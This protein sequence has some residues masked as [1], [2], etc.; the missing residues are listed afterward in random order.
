M[1]KILL[2]TACVLCIAKMAWTEEMCID[3]VGGGTYSTLQGALYIAASNGE[4]DTIKVVQGT[5]TRASGNFNYY[6]TEGK[7]I[8][9]RGGYTAGCAAGVED[10]SLTILDASGESDTDRVLSILNYGSGNIEID[11]FT[12]RNGI[13]SA[14]IGGPGGGIYA[15]CYPSTGPAGDITIQNNII[16]NNSCAETYGGGGVAATSYANSS[17]SSGN[18][19]FSNN[20]VTGNT[21]DR[22]GGGIAIGSSSDSGI[23]GSVTVSNNFIDGNMTIN[24]NG[25]GGGIYAAS[26]SN[27]GT[28]GS[29]LLTGNTITGNISGGHGG[30]AATSIST[31]AGGS[32][33]LITL[34]DNIIIG[35]SSTYFNGHGG[36]VYI[37]TQTFGTGKAGSAVLTNNII[38]GN[39]SNGNTAFGGGL[40]ADSYTLTGTEGDFTLTNNTIVENTSGYYG[41]GIFLSGNTCYVT[42]NIIWDNSAAT[43]GEDVYIYFTSTAFGYNNDYHN[44]SGTWNGGYGNNIDTNPLFAGPDD[45]HL[46]SSSPCVNA[47]AN[48]APEL[49]DH[50]FEGNPRIRGGSVDIGADEYFQKGV[51]SFL[52]LLLN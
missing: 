39:T 47:G 45:Y 51:L 15:L 14:S 48:T 28:A 36:G 32:G 11:G 30:G 3:S 4:D 16:T 37:W 26:S 46:Q 24:E 5:Y 33:G 10:P 13:V 49:P 50:D 17:S 1:K 29:V 20:T 44:M 43:T 42:N 6:S 31:D 9:L 35:N 23:S 52:M 2:L 22:S 7:S 34:I 21:A 12:I 41:G 27:S 19:I 8:T 18:V 38:A 40:S 25:N